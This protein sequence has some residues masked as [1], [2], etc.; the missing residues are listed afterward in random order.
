MRRVVRFLHCYLRFPRSAIGEVEIQLEVGGSSVPAS[1]IRPLGAGPLPGWILLHGVTVPGRHHPVLTRFAHSL[2]STGATVLIPEVPAWRQL[3]LAPQV[4]DATIAAAARH[5]C[6]RGDVAGDHLNLV[7]F[8]FGATQA[9]MSATKPGIREH[10][11]SVVAFGGYCDLERTLVTMMT[12]EHEWQGVRRRLIPDPYGRWIAVANYLTGVPE[13]EHMEELQQAAY[14][15]AMESGMRGVFAAEAEYDPFKAE[16]RRRLPREQ[17]EIWDLIAPPA[18]TQ[19]PAGAG[20]EFAKR[21]F[22]GVKEREPGLDP[23][24]LLPLIDQRVVLV[25]GRDDRLIPFTESLRLKAELPPQASADVAITALFAHSR[26]AERLGILNYPRE[27]A[28]YI[29]LLQRALQPV[30][31]R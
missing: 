17:Q 29:A 21:L 9:L 18:G 3:R 7:G 12:G 28:R 19:V 4:A 16:L 1:L 10:V 20:R 26:G 6:S 13:F 2:A 27:V 31:A 5:L 22:A 23:R 25:H 11:R 30:R 15:L 24:P 14:A 8:S